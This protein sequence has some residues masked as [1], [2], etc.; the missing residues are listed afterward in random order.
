MLFADTLGFLKKPKKHLEFESICWH[1]Q[2]K[3]Y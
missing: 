3:D 2:L 1:K